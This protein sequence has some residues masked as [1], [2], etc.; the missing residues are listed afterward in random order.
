MTLADKITSILIEPTTHC[1]ARCPQCARFTETGYLH[2]ELQLKHLALNN[3]LGITKQDLPNLNRIQFEGDKGDP[4]MVPYL[5]Q[6][7][8]H[9]SWVN[10]VGLVT[11]GSIRSKSWWRNLG[12]KKNLLVTFS[13]DGL[14]DTNHL[15]RVNIDFNRVISN[16]R[17]YIEAGGQA[18]WKCIVFK[19]NQH[20]LHTIR[21]L[22]HDMGFTRVE[23]AECAVSRFNGQTKFPVFKEGKF[24]HEI[25]P[26]TIPRQELFQLSENFGEHHNRY[27][28]F[29][30]KLNLEMLCPYLNRNTIYIN[31]RGYVIPCCMLHWDLELEY[32]GT[33]SFRKMLGGNLDSISLGHYSIRDILATNFYQRDLNLSLQST[34]TAMFQCQRSCGHVIPAN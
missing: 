4:C 33:D 9:F 10:Q 27:W 23:F 13:I 20:Q 26:G 6:W 16:A 12:S 5:E 32:P 28:V 15:Y 14:S 17:A 30:D 31:Y 1:N 34:K 19:H 8:E 29:S 22:A 24:L 18:I 25:L 21:N 7:I 2:P 3:L 11:N